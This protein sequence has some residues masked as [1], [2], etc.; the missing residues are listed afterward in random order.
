MVVI[1]PGSLFTSIV[2]NLLISGITAALAKSSAFKVYVC[3]V[4]EEPGQTE[5]YSVSEHLDVVRHYGGANAVHAVVANL[6]LPKGPTPAGLDF[7]S[8]DKPWC[9]DVLLVESDV[10]DDSS[11]DRT[12]RHDSVKLSH[13]IAQ[14][15]RKYRG[16]RRRLPRIRL[17]A[18]SSRSTFE[19]QVDNSDKQ[20]ESVNSP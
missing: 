3:N 13:A 5:G 4:A 20:T 8:V 9:D 12:A 17:E 1:G 16:N 14:A 18:P 11:A 10:I 6:N 7:I 19:H 2:P 15:Y